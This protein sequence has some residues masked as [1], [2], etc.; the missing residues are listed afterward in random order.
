MIARIVVMAAGIGLSA[1]AVAWWGGPMSGPWAGNG[2][3]PNYGLGSGYGAGGHGGEQFR[4]GDAAGGADFSMSLSG[5][6]SSNMRGYGSGYG[7]G[8]AWG[9]GY[10]HRAPYWGRYAPYAYAPPQSGYGYAQPAPPVLAE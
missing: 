1:T 4:G 9:R 2:W 10:N 5:R 6:A 7:A 3:V 8:D